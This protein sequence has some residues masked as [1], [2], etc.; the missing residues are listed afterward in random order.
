V[1]FQISNAFPLTIP[2][3]V[4]SRS[5]GARPRPAPPLRALPSAREEDGAGPHYP[6]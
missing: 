6:E 1:R 4:K 3:R 2:G 5:P